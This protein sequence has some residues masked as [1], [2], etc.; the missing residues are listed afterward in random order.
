L[1]FQILEKRKKK[2]KKKKKGEEEN[3]PEEEEEEEEPEPL[4]M[5]FKMVVNI[6][7]K[8]VKF[9]GRSIGRDL[10]LDGDR[11][12][13]GNEEWVYTEPPLASD[14]EEEEDDLL[15]EDD[16]LGIGLTEEQIA[17]LEPK[18]RKKLM[19]TLKKK[20]KEEAK[21]K[22]LEDREREKMLARQQELAKQEE[23]R[24]LKSEKEQQKKKTEAE[25]QA[26]RQESK[27]K[28]ELEKQEKEFELQVDKEYEQDIQEA[29]KLEKERRRK[30]KKKRK[31]SNKKTPSRSKS[32]STPQATESDSKS[33]SSGNPKKL[34][35]SN[36][37]SSIRTRKH[38][39]E[40]AVP[41]SGAARM[42]VKATVT[43]TF[44]EIRGFSSRKEGKMIY[45]SWRRGMKKENTGETSR[46][47]CEKKRVDL[48]DSSPITFS[49]RFSHTT[50]QESFEEKLI[51][52]HIKEDT[53]KKAHLLGDVSLNLSDYLP[54]TTQEPVSRQV[55]LPVASTKS[56]K[57][58][59]TLV[60]DL[61]ITRGAS[62]QAPS[63]LTL[64]KKPSAVDSS[65]KGRAK[66]LFIIQPLKLDKINT[67]GGYLF[68]KWQRGTKKSNQGKTNVIP[69]AQP[70]WTEGD[71]PFRLNCTMEKKS[72]G[73]FHTKNLHI[74]LHHCS[75]PDGKGKQLGKATMNLADFTSHQMQQQTMITLQHKKSVVGLLSLDIRSEWSQ[76]EGKRLVEAPKDLSNV[77]SDR[78][79]QMDDGRDFV[80]QTAED[81]SEMSEA[82]N[83]SFEDFDNEDS[84][85][86]VFAEDKEEEKPKALQRVKSI[87]SEK[88]AKIMSA[89]HVPGKSHHAEKESKSQESHKKNIPS[90]DKKPSAAE[91]SE[92]SK[93]E[94]SALEEKLATL[95]NLS[96]EAKRLRDETNAK[97]KEVLLYQKKLQE[98]QDTAA[99]T[100]KK[101]GGNK[102]EQLIAV[103]EQQLNL[104]REQSKKNHNLSGETKQQCKAKEREV[105]ELKQQ[106]LVAE[107]LGGQSKK[108][109]VSDKK[110]AEFYNRAQCLRKNLLFTPRDFDSKT[111]KPVCVEELTAYYYDHKDNLEVILELFQMIGLMAKNAGKDFTS[112]CYWLS[113]ATGLCSSLEDE[114][115]YKGNIESR[116]IVQPKK[117]FDT[118]DKI[119]DASQ[120]ETAMELFTYDI[121]N[122]LFVS[123]IY[124]ELDMYL[125]ESFINGGDLVFEQRVKFTDPK[126]SVEVT[127]KILKKVLESLLE[128]NCLPVV[129]HQCFSQ[130]IY[131]ISA[132]LFN[133]VITTP[134]YCSPRIGLQI[135]MSVSHLISWFH[136]QVKYIPTIEKS[137]F[138]MNYI[139]EIA[140]VLTLATNES[141]FQEEHLKVTFPSLNLAQL[142]KVIELYSPDKYAPEPIPVQV[143]RFINGACQRDSSVRS[144]SLDLEP[145]LPLS[146]ITSI[147]GSGGTLSAQVSK[148]GHEEEDDE[149]YSFD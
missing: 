83:D 32:P 142:R 94:L 44:T 114:D 137:L 87:T 128:N 101:T 37:I 89:L 28:K 77:S 55:E 38:K 74:E 6:Q 120:L 69:A 88:T 12:M 5:A 125:E 1:E 102:A 50:K 86:D 29:K 113:V 35:I 58:T 61:S 34:S 96:G 4:T 76:F 148:A 119:T 40:A 65:K 15:N 116:G 112:I 138:H 144:M 7:A 14:D 124:D 121:Y 64:A 132:S 48:S 27:T 81:C 68:L 60:F 18:A 3:E 73:K 17:E 46:A 115:I 66:I 72:N 25:L 70:F 43:I 133:R 11:V 91:V 36:S 147:A 98:M 93:K 19:R 10:T 105:A 123:Q 141:V 140:N 49:A 45:I 104:V 108:V 42:K 145:V 111:K 63:A 51:S 57:Q 52:F 79:V 22:K 47:F 20:A 31:K 33:K 122:T 78:I 30:R 23:Q 53:T 143:K 92:K 97:Q 56:D 8:F 103:F 149:E 129:I 2:K 62:V 110:E 54:T 118:I 75:S 135:K 126:R 13:I 95:S 9:K 39:I 131:Y 106:L 127:I 146:E 130:L 71:S 80:V 16:P 136:Q 82:S 139:V 59:L 99:K 134:S 100:L 21:R 85:G 107:K 117:P 84:E 24:Q 90:S 109:S 41:M 26:Q 67:S